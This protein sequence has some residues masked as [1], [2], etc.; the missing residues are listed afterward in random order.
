MNEL[1]YIRDLKTK[2]MDRIAEYR[3]YLYKNPKL[4]DL[5]I[6]VTSR[7]NAHC[8][9]CGS[10]CDNKIQADEISADYLKRTLRE[11]ADHYNPDEILLNI[12][13]GEPLMRKDLFDIMRYASDLGFRWG[14]TSN[15]MLIN[16]EI[17]QKMIETKMETISISLDGLKD[18]HESFRHVSGSFDKIIENIK[19]LQQTPSIA[20]T[21]VT[22]VVNKRNINELEDLYKLMQDIGI[23]SWRVINV[24]PIGRARDNNDILLD[25]RDYKYLFDFIAK[26][27][28][29]RLIENI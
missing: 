29:E 6:E 7:C 27:R 18:T 10:R 28:E 21:Q 23:M 17:I 9:H 20:I 22:T 13:G 3:N 2:N 5:F 25:T 8:D 4:K 1:E 24:D 19:K 16:D 15:G 26:K 14:M 11:I 12:T